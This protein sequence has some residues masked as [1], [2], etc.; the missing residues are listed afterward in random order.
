MDRISWMYTCW[1]RTEL[2]VVGSFACECNEYGISCFGQMPVWTLSMSEGH[3]L[4]LTAKGIKR[5]PER[6]GWTLL[7][8]RF[9]AASEA[10]WISGCIH[11]PP[12]HSATTNF[13]TDFGLTYLRICVWVLQKSATNFLNSICR[14]GRSPNTNLELRGRE[15]TFNVTFLW[16]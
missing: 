8:N 7:A 4:W 15:L 10:L 2:A 11:P 5:K 14:F 13:A 12:S 16:Y 9:P 3:S 6:C 1:P